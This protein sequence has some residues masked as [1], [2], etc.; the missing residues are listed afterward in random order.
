MKALLMEGSQK[1]RMVDMPM[2]EDKDKAIIKIK[3]MGIC[4]TEVAAYRGVLPMGIYPRTLGHE[5]AGEVVSLPAG[6]T[7]IKVG[8]KVALEPY[9]TCGKCYPCSL[10]RTNCC[11]QLECL[12]V[13][14]YG[15]YSEY[16]AHEPELCHKIEGDMSWEEMALVEPLTIS[17]HGVTRARVKEG[18][19]VAIVGAGPIGVLAAL[20]ALA[21]G[22]VPIVIDP[23]EKRLAYVQSL[24]IPHVVNPMQEDAVEKIKAITNGRMAEAV[25]ECSGNVRAS[26]NTIDYVSYGGRI[27]FTG[28]THD[29]VPMPMHIAIKKE[30]DLLGS[31]NSAKEFPVAI[32]LIQSK[33]VDVKA[34]ISNIIT[35]D[36]LGEYLG[37]LTQNPNDYMKVVA[38][39]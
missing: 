10:G 37:K 33:K 9:R 30:L 32:E 6:V 23:M 39:L 14:T 26:R 19:H 29:D 20:V 13:H 11:E 7:H 1:V 12:G 4:G 35:F 34:L 28:H 22:A 24:G 27:A 5:I 18:E 17:L 8:D 38:L 36:E 16:F 2:P 21:K 15:A 3:A 25:L 31:R